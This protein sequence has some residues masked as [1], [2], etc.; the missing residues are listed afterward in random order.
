M[1]S[2]ITASL[3]HLIQ[4][5]DL[6]RHNIELG[7]ASPPT[8]LQRRPYIIPFG[9]YLSQMS[10]GQVD[11]E[12]YNAYTVGDYSNDESLHRSLCYSNF[13]EPRSRFKD[14]WVG[15]YFILDDAAGKGRHFAMLDP[16]GDPS[17]LGNINPTSLRL[18]PELDQKLITF[19]THDGQPGYQDLQRF[20]QE[21]YFRLKPGT[22]MH[23]D[24]V[25]DAE[26]RTWTRVTAT[27]ETLA[28]V[29]DTHL[30]H[31]SLFTS[32][33]TYI[34]LPTRTVYR[35]VPP[36]HPVDLRGRAWVRYFAGVHKPGFWAVVYGNGSLFTR[37]DGVAV[38]T[39]HGPL[40]DE[41]DQMFL[42]MRIRALG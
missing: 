34:G 14:C 26:G 42:D 9:E 36:W 27:Y 32:L 19:S 10:Q 16:A 23:L 31:M 12:C 37:L 35:W 8:G 2:C 28:A 24:H 40:R 3:A 18:L 5:E 21:F 25:P 41:V 4:R 22:H 29:T 13:V 39:W 1:L 11:I 6:R 20:E 7:F 38:N 30:T 17:D 15:C 33:R